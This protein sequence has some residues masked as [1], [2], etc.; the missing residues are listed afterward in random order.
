MSRV[1]QAWSSMSSRSRFFVRRLRERLWVKPLM[2]CLLSIAAAFTAGL[3][4]Q[5]EFEYIPEISRESVETL[6]SILSASMLVIAVFAVGAM[7]SAYASASNAATP[8]TFP[9]VVSD[10]VSQ[11]ALSTFIGSFIFSIIAQIALMNGYYEEQGRFALFLLTALVFS[12]V[13][14]GFVRWVDR[15]ARLGRLGSTIDK[16]EAVVINTLKQRARHPTM[17]ANKAG[18]FETGIAIYADRVGYV[19][20][21]DV[22]KLQRLAEQQDFR[23]QVAAMPGSFATPGQALAYINGVIDDEAAIASIKEAFILGGDRTF[24]EDPRFGLVVLAE[25]ASR[26]LSPAV[27]DPGTAIDIIGTLLRMF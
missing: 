27:N 26:A 4:D 15:I 23:L 19:Q 21:I 12:V 1:L 22:A 25:I 6:L 10:D 16:V 5:F 9:V 11:N 3:A 13:I 8:R 20:H 14:L 2:I 7:L 24:D 18:E 17:R